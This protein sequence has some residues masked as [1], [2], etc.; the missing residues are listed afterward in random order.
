MLVMSQN[1][2]SSLTALLLA[3]ALNALA[4]LHGITLLSIGASQQHVGGI[5]DLSLVATLGRDHA[6]EPSRYEHAE[7]DQEQTDMG[8][9]EAEDV[10]GVIAEIVERW[11]GEAVD[12]GENGG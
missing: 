11:V 1:K 5:W 10:K 12:D 3:G 7:A 8:D 6:V 9:S 4:R 2:I